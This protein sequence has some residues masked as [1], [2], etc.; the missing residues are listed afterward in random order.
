MAA[1]VRVGQIVPVT[2][3]VPNGTLTNVDIEYSVDGAAYVFCKDAGDVDADNITANPFQWKIPSVLD[4]NV[5]VRVSTADPVNKP[6]LAAPTTN[7]FGKTFSDVI[8]KLLFMA[9]F[10]IQLI[11]DIIWRTAV[12]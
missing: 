12:N 10:Q 6:A 1:F 7:K 8:L 9:I 4:T 5:V 2:W 3:G 11:R